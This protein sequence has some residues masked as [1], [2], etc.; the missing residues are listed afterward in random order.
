VTLPLFPHMSED[1]LRQ[2]IQAVK[3]FS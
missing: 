1:Q 3:N 2:V